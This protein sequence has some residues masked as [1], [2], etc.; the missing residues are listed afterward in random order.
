MLS[1]NLKFFSASLKGGTE[2]VYPFYLLK[3]FFKAY[4]SCNLML[5]QECKCDALVLSL[6]STGFIF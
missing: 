3:A 6:G 1:S 4:F 5:L 2:T